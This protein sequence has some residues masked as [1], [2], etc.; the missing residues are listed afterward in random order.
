VRWRRRL[1]LVVAFVAAM[2]PL[3]AVGAEEAPRAE[4]ADETDEGEF[5]WSLPG[6]GTLPLD[7]SEQRAPDDVA[8]AVWSNPEADRPGLTPG[9]A[10]VVVPVDGGRVTPGSPPVHIELPPQVSDRAETVVEVLDADVAGALSPFGVG[11]TLEFGDVKP[12]LDAVVPIEFDYTDVAVMP[13]GRAIERLQ[14]TLRTG[15]SR[16]EKAGI[17]CT[18]SVHLDTVNDITARTLRAE[19]PDDMLTTLGSGDAAECRVA[20]F[21]RRF[22]RV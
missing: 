10:S 20:V 14:L 12:V 9:R 22:R 17:V 7:A 1:V 3:T 18:D 4:V 8:L 13:G 16:D 19:N 11:F 6:P 21:R 5:D 15:C 2:A